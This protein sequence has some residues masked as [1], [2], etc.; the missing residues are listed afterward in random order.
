MSWI[1]ILTA[2]IAP[3]TALLTYFYLK[4]RYESEPIHLVFKVFLLGVLLVFPTMVLQR[5]FVLLLGENELIYSFFI[6]SGIEEFFKWF[7]LYFLI[8]R[9]S[10]F[11]EPYDGIVYA[12]GISIGFA[13]LEN[14][15]YAFY[16]PSTITTL[17]LRGLLP[18]SGHALFGVVMGYYLGKAKFSKE[19]RIKYL[20]MSLTMPILWHGM[21]DYILLVMKA[22]WVWFM[23]PFM[24]ILWMRSLLKVNNANSKSPFRAI[25]TD[26]EIQS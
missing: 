8:F 5:G 15:I 9:L 17:F 19:G 12:V 18:V 6:S 2:A 16:Y 24:F 10:E 3:G 1:A 11:D 22:Y 4:D 13:T 23:I 26:E 14:V 20:L 25:R 21:F 7:L